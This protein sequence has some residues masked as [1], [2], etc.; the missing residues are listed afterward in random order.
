MA[1][2][3]ASGYPHPNPYP[4]AAGAGAGA[5]TNLQTAFPFPVVQLTVGYLSEEPEAMHGFLSYLEDQGVQVYSFAKYVLDVVLPNQAMPEMRKLKFTVQA[6]S[7]ALKQNDLEMAHDY[8]DCFEQQFP[9]KLSINSPPLMLL[10]NA[11]RDGFQN[12]DQFCPDCRNQ[13]SRFFTRAEPWSFWVRYLDQPDLITSCLENHD[14]Y[15]N[16]SYVS[17]IFSL[18]C[19]AIVKGLKTLNLPKNK[20]FHPDETN[21]DLATIQKEI[22]Q[23]LTQPS[24]KSYSERFEEVALWIS[25]TFRL[26]DLQIDKFALTDAF[27]CDPRC[28][29]VWLSACFQPDDS[30]QIQSIVRFGV[31]NQ[32]QMVMNLD[33]V[34]Q[35]LTTNEGAF[36]DLVFAAVSSDDNDV[37]TCI[38]SLPKQLESYVKEGKDRKALQIKFYS[39]HRIIG[40]K[41][42]D[43]LALA[44]SQENYEMTFQLMRLTAYQALPAN[45]KD[46]LMKRMIGILDCSFN[47]SIVRLMANEF[48]PTLVR[49]HLEQL[50]SHDQGWASALLNSKGYQQISLIEFHWMLD[51][52]LDWLTDEFFERLVADHRFSSISSRFVWEPK[53]WFPRV[54]TER[55][56][57]PDS[58]YELNVTNASKLISLK[59]FNRLKDVHS[60]IILKLLRKAFTNHDVPFVK[61]L[62]ATPQFAQITE[63]DFNELYHL[64]IVQTS[65]VV[66]AFL[67]APRVMAM[68]LAVFGQSVVILASRGLLPQLQKLIDHPKFKN[69]DPLCVVDATTEANKLADKNLAATISALLISKKS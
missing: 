15:D 51:K 7:Y 56:S 40:K 24:N 69:V 48:S 31:L 21:K 29:E 65:E 20:P 5:S 67:Q 44:V 17:V 54:V 32:V 9:V 43:C 27:I 63:A 34:K 14:F 47:L 57:I 64:A 3:A 18:V 62:M 23:F 28:F 12:I 4:Q 60:S 11:L 16:E 39:D 61:A 22:D 55:H 19:V 36:T 58:F 35:F 37:L 52:R 25:A 38:L 33:G 13:T 26:V 59:K 6:L 41:F 10:R 66:E 45:H 49:T 53:T 68:N 8:Y 30:D 46:I 42:E 50:H 1:S 2:A